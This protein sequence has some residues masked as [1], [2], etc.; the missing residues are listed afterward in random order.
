ML[1]YAVITMTGSSGSS[2]LAARSTPKPSPS[3]SLRSVRTTTGR[4]RRSSRIGLG[5]VAR[6]EDGMALRLERVPEH[7]PERILVFDY[8]YGERGGH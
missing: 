7:R 6:L 1:P 4:A 3:G 8:E 2:S 5:L